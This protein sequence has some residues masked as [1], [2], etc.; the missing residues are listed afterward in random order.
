[1]TG[2]T[3]GNVYDEQQR[4]QPYATLQFPGTYHLAFRDLPALIR[5][6]NH[7]SRALDFGCGTGRSARFLRNL[8]L[9]V[10]GVDTSQAMLDHFWAS[11]IRR[12]EKK[13][14][15]TIFAL[16]GKR[17]L[18]RFNLTNSFCNTNLGAYGVRYLFVIYG[19]SVAGTE[20]VRRSFS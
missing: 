15:L 12:E 8:G 14:L 17:I 10:I 16:R 2:H 9:K 7:G 3:F 19:F 4:A 6:Y 11:K 18:V 13:I 5:R 20:N 1:M